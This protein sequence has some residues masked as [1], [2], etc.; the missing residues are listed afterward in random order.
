MVPWLQGFYN[1]KYLTI[2]I[3]Q[4]FLILLAQCSPPTQDFRLYSIQGIDQIQSS[5]QWHPEA[6]S[7]NFGRIKTLHL[8]VV[9]KSARDPV[10][11]VLNYAPLDRIEVFEDEQETRRLYLTGDTLPLPLD[12]IRLP[13]LYFPF[14]RISLPISKFKAKA[15]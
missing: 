4:G 10:Y 9:P 14:L 8:K 11:L 5:I 2:L 15:R 7:R 1:H 12:P 6:A 13:I 3:V